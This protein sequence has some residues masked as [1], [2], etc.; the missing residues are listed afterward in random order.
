VFVP[1]LGLFPL[2]W[3]LDSLVSVSDQ[4]VL[5]HS[6][7]YAW[8]RGYLWMTS[9]QWLA[10]LIV[11]GKLIRQLQTDSEVLQSRN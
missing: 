2:H 10:G 8:H 4:I 7:F 6:L 3:Q 9:L 5:D 11:Y 1:T